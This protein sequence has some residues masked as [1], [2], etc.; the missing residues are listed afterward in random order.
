M[1]GLLPIKDV[2]TTARNICEALEAAQQKGIVHR[3]IKP[4]NL[5]INRDRQVKVLDFVLAKALDDTAA[6]ASVSNSP[7]LGRFGYCRVSCNF[8][9]H[10][11]QFPV[12]VARI[13]GRSLHRVKEKSGAM[14]RC[15]V[16]EH[17]IP[18]C[19]DGLRLPNSLKSLECLSR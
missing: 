9:L 11:D 4:A 12:L 16:V 7:T 8:A 5:K 6:A 18:R 17:A 13:L 3:E 14:T 2:F 1:G 15:R 19:R 10:Q